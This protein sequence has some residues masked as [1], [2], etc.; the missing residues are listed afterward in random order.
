M[1]GIA[2]LAVGGCVFQD[3]AVF[4]D[5]L[6]RG[7]LPELAVKAHVAAV[8]MRSARF[9]FGKV[10]RRSVQ[11]AFAVRDAVAHATDQRADIAVQ[12]RI[13]LDA[14]IAQQHVAQI[15]FTIGHVDGV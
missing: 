7:C 14:G 10:Q 13:A 5:A 3:Q 12:R 6:D 4:A 9:V 11:R 2:F 8:Q 15:A 1:S